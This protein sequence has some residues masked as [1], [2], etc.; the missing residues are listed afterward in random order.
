MK[1]LTLALLIALGATQ[2]NCGNEE[3]V[4]KATTDAVIAQINKS[5][6]GSKNALVS[7][8]KDNQKLLTI[9][10]A[11][12]A[13]WA[14]TGLAGW[15]FQP[16]NVIDDKTSTYPVT[17]DKEGNFPLVAELDKDGKATNKMVDMGFFKKAAY[18]SATYTGANKVADFA[19]WTKGKTTDGYAWVKE[20]KW[21]T[22]G[23]VAALAVIIFAVYDLNKEADKS[24]VKN[25]YKSVFGDAKEE[26]KP[27]T[28]AV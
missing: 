25:F 15:Y 24:V 14:V 4:N 18:Y 13:V 17:F 22:A 28:P 16:V 23:I 20:N 26:A 11:V 5:N 8:V 6:V 21:T 12:A 27:A 7:F 9:A 3:V 2:A 19:A 1:K 10:A